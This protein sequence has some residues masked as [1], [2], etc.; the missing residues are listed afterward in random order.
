MVTL[1]ADIN[2]TEGK[3]P[4]Q[5]A[6]EGVIGQLLE[7]LTLEMP[8]NEIIELTKKWERAWKESDRKTAWEKQCEEN[9]RYWK[10]KQY[11]GP[12]PEE[13]RP[14]VDN[15]IFESLETY[16]PQATRRNP[17][18]LVELAWSQDYSP[19]SNEYIKK[20][21]ERLAYIADERRLR[22]KLKTAARYWSMYLIGPVKYGWDMDHNMPT[23]RCVRPQKMILDPNA[24]IDEEGYTGNHIGEY[25]KKEA[26]ILLRLIENEPN[27]EESKKKID[28]I[29][30]GNLGT[31]IQ[32][33][34]FWTNEYLCWRIDDVILLKRKNIHWNWGTE[35]IDE[36]VDDYG[37]VTPAVEP[38]EGVNHFPTPRMPY[39]FLSVF[40]LGT[41]PMDDT[42]LISQSL[43]N[44]DLINK[45]NRQ[46]T[47]NVDGM[48][49]GMVVSLERTGFTDAQ[50]KKATKAIQNGGTVAI[51]NGSPQE[52]VMR[53]PT[54]GLPPDVFT[55]LNDTRLRLRDIFGTRG[56]SPAG[57]GTESTVRGKILNRGLDTDRI[58]GGVSEYLEQLADGMYNWMLQLLYVYDAEF[59]FSPNKLPPK[60]KISVKE[61]SLLPK[62]S[63]SLANQAI[64]LASSGKMA[65][66]DLYKRLDYPNPEELA[67]NVWLETNAPDI[68]YRNNPLVQE[69]VQRQQQQAQA[70]SEAKAQ[71]E[72]MKADAKLNADL[73]KE[74][75]KATLKNAQP[76]QTPADAA[77]S[78]VPTQNA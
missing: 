61:G 20:V 47:K 26:S 65:L 24:T 57:V 78:N 42:S 28:E 56:S 46:I 71:A 59:Q 77:L 67:A 30:K 2:K 35:K 74:E 45:R 41:Q 22:L 32:Y 5:E 68:L 19:E 34:E 75:Y 29:T 55:Q 54:P 33:I 53:L 25:C 21:K 43:S 36:K 6:K 17:E 72:M 40:N 1:G 9:E 10:G 70:E 66:I 39:D 69:A 12:K 15:M 49:G 64:D 73:K 51:P 38:I 44:Q 11:Y 60:V 37:V 7:E 52:S 3:S 16:L 8:D 13:E 63:T 14:M 4:N 76:S 48:N 18:P 62:D 58:G 50:A 27:Y 23:I 31:E